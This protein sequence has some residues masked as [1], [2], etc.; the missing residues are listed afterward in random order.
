MRV[1][2]GREYTPE[3]PLPAALKGDGTRPLLYVNSDLGT[4][5]MNTDGSGAQTIVTEATQETIFPTWSSDGSRIGLLKTSIT[6]EDPGNLRVNQAFITLVLV[7]DAN[8]GNPREIYRTAGAPGFHPIPYDPVNPEKPALDVEIKALDWSPDTKSLA[9]SICATQRYYSGA[10]NDSICWVELREIATGSLI[11]KAD[12]LGRAN[13]SS[14]NRLLAETIDGY[15]NRATGIWQIDLNANPPVETLVI[16][17]ADLIA[18]RVDRFPTWS[19]DGAQFVTSRDVS[20]Y[21][22]YSDGS[23]NFHK[24]I[25]LFDQGNPVGRTLMVADQGSTPANFTWS[26]DGK[27]VLYSLNQGDDSDVWWLD[28]ATGATGKVTTDGKSIAANWRP[29]CVGALCNTAST[30]K[31]YVPAVTR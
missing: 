29:T 4:A 3:S 17:G 2:S 26:P 11:Y 5:R 19:P 1:I 15:D 22:Y 25:M 7:T 16:P 6:Q 28:V 23:R 20:G 24:V 30:H 8:G 27:Y 14:T 10:V 18:L 31:L 12:R 9:L 13:W 21:S